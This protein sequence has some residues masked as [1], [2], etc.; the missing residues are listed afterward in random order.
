M[1]TFS[2][3]RLS[4]T[5]DDWPSGAKRVRC[6]F[7][8]ERHPSK[9]QWRFVRTTTGKPKRMTYSGPGAIVDGSDGKTYL[10]QYASAYGFVTAYASNLLCADP[11]TLGHDHTLWP[12]DER[13]R[14]L[15]SLIAQANGT[16][17]PAGM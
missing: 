14:E 12:K 4:A 17:P 2:N 11:K 6:T 9:P 8:M 16:E 7:A 3:P 1:I 15:I 13:Y 5:F 10:L